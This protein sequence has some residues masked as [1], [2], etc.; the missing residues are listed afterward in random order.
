M[1]KNV[2]VHLLAGVLLL[3]NFCLADGGYGAATAFFYL[4]LYFAGLLVLIIVAVVSSR[5]FP[6][7]MSKF[8]FFYIT[9]PLLVLVWSSTT[10]RPKKAQEQAENEKWNAGLGENIRAFSMYCQSRKQV[11]HK[12]AKISKDLTIAVRID[13]GFKGYSVEY[14]AHAIAA[15]LRSL[16]DSCSRLN[17]VEGMYGEEYRLYIVCGG[18][19]Y[20]KN[21]VTSASHD[22]VFGGSSDSAPAP[23]RPDR[24][25]MSSSSV[26]IVERKSGTVL[27]EDRLY[28][29]HGMAGGDDV[30]PKGKTQ[31]VDIIS[32]VFF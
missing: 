23:F 28:F 30:C 3:P 22:L 7:V 21:V 11:I 19:S 10:E 24:H 6:G 18:D 26:T 14:N 15:V 25:A 31:V 1:S 12:P 27:A 20:A 5:K 16:P 2:P 32:K 29:L 17:Y 9:I 13:P 4:I 8:L